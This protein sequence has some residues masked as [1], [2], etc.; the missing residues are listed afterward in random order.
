MI[1][2]ITS[3]SDLYGVLAYNFLKIEDDKASILYSKNF[4]SE[5][6]S[7]YDALD[8]FSPYFLANK[9]TK[10][11]VFHVSLNP[12]LKDNIDKETMIKIA[13]EYMERMGYSN[14][15]Y[16]VFSHKDIER[17]HIHI[18]SSRVDIEGN[19]IKNSF[20]R[21]RSFN[22]TRDIE[23]KYNLHP[24][25]NQEIRESNAIK[26]IDFRSDNWNGQLKRNLNEIMENYKFKD[27]KELKTILSTFNIDFEVTNRS[28]RSGL[29]YFITDN[30][31]R[32]RTKPLHASKL[33]KNL[34]LKRIE[35]C[36][37]NKRQKKEVKERLLNIVSEALDKSI[38]EK[39][40]KIALK[41]QGVDVVLNKNE[42]GRIYG[43]SYVDHYSKS[44]FKGSDL[45]KEVS[46]N[47]V[48]LKSEDWI[49]HDEDKKYVK[50]NNNNEDFNPSIHSDS[51]TYFLSNIL[52]PYYDDIILQGK[53]RN[54]KRKIQ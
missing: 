11:T 48:E 34:G 37:T 53:K 13:D 51:F 42:E 27:L 12:S 16:L 40:F 6:E 10:K 39:S 36:F 54:R 35:S 25:T 30:E 1:A 50:S 18:V 22:I 31:G 9:R 14:Q 38:S 20:E 15:P 19:M 23:E 41:K 32:K 45:G 24:A 4:A 29:S 3:G 43:V 8:E 47:S 26:K 46:A 33:S 44:V 49:K 7:I 52:D 28:D 2:K 21:R 17:E 5:P